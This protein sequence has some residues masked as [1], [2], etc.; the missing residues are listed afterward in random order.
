MRRSGRGRRRSFRTRRPCAAA[1]WRHRRRRGS[2][3]GRRTSCRRPHRATSSS[4]RC[5]TSTPPASRPSRRRPGRPGDPRGSR[6]GPP[7][8]RRR[9][10]PGWRRCCSWPSGPRRRASSVSR[11]A[12]PSGSSCAANPRC[13]HP[14]AAWTRRTPCAAPSARASRVR[15]GSSPCAR[16]APSR[17]RRPGNLCGSRR[18]TCRGTCWWTCWCQTWKA[19]VV[20]ECTNRAGAFRHRSN[21][22]GDSVGS[23]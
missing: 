17:D 14:R 8:P 11:S 10:D 1:S 9:R 15:R 20:R 12:P 18:W 7:R 19:S 21:Q 16:T 2:C 5:T 13:G 23:A 6:A 22:P 3:S 4:G